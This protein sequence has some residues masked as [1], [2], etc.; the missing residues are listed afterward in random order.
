MRV[1]GWRSLTFAAGVGG[2][3]LIML[4]AGEAS[5]SGKPEDLPNE[6]VVVPVGPDGPQTNGV[7]KKPGDVIGR[8]RLE[9]DLCVFDQPIG[10]GVEP[11]YDGP[12][13]VMWKFDEQCRAVITSITKS[14]KPGN[15]EL[16]NGGGI[17]APVAS[18][19]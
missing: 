4:T 18:E 15:E 17:V 6:P 16:T 1:P 13:E 10:V 19:Q 2:V 8:A 9:N 7:S 12:V 14:K 3:S 5:S 11:G